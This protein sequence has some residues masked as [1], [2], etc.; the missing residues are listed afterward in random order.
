MDRYLD[1]FVVAEMLRGIKLGIDDFN[2]DS[3]RCLA[4]Y[5]SEVTITY[6]GVTMTLPFGGYKE[7]ATHE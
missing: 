1:R 2:A 4:G 6:D 3:P 5:P 7:E